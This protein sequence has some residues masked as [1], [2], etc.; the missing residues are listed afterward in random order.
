M[1][2]DEL[3]RKAV[4]GVDVVPIFGV[5]GS[6][7]TSL[8][9]GLSRV[10]HTYMFVSSGQ[11]VR[12][13]GV[14]KI[15][16]DEMRKTGLYP[17]ES[18]LRGR[19]AQYI[20]DYRHERPFVQTILMDGFP[21][22]QD[23]VRWLFGA[24][25]FVSASIW[26]TAR[27]WRERLARRAREDQRVEKDRAI[28]QLGLIEDAAFELYDRGIRNVIIDTTGMSQAEVRTAAIRGM[29]RQIGITTIEKGVK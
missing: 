11:I 19:I 12:R 2:E 5:P 8:A 27:D 17:H 26:L 1:H 25:A 28:K 18:V 21:R 10:L 20:L 14:N 16:G 29:N 3:M 22:T 13:I 15:E 7:K 23:Q 4:A 9:M 6:G 24:G